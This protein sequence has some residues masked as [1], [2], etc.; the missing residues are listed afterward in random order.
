MDNGGILS[1]NMQP[2]DLLELVEEQ[3]GPSEY[4]SKKYTHNEMFWIGYVYRY[5]SYTNEKTSASIYREIKPKELR[6]LYLPYHTLDPSQAIERI[7][8]A[9]GTKADS[10]NDLMRQYEIYR[11]IRGSYGAQDSQ[12]S[13]E[14]AESADSE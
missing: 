6:D 14:I 10:E 1:S 11:K 4:G 12:V 9:K 7:L 2:S 3:Y 8:E 13:L 5:Y